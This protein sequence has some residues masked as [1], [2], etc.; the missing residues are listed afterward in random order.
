MARSRALSAKEEAEHRAQE[1]RDRAMARI[2]DQVYSVDR[3][4]LDFEGFQGDF[5]KLFE[6]PKAGFAAL[7]SRLQGIDRETVISILSSREGVTREDAE[8]LVSKGESI[9]AK[10]EQTADKAKSGMDEMAD[11]ILQAKESALER[12]RQAEDEIRR[13]LEEAKRQSLEQVEATRKVTAAAAW[14][15]LAIA[16]VSGAAATLGALTAVM[17][18]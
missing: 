10:A 14:W 12:A 13:R 9:R 7:K 5:R 3:P 16:V 6:D 1:T 8:K 17:T 11:R 4:E 2:R 18:T 15:L